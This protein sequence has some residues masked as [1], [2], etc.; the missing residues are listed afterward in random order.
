M[1]ENQPNPT[2]QSSKAAPTTITPQR[3]ATVQ[4]PAPPS[5]RPG[6]ILSTVRRDPF[7][8]ITMYLRRLSKEQFYGIVSII[9]RDG[10]VQIVRTEQTLKLSDIPHSPTPGD[11]AAALGTTTATM[12]GAQ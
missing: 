2:S 7:E 1:V 8:R 5:V 4:P 6:T 9:L 11:T 10:A 12:G 3:S